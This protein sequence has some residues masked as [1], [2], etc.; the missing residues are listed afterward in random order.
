V[1]RRDT[2]QDLR[3]YRAQ[4]AL[5]WGR[6]FTNLDEIGRYIESLMASNWWAKE[7][8][9]IQD[10]EIQ[11]T[12]PRSWRA[13]SQRVPS[14]RIWLPRWGFSELAILHEIAHCL[15]LSGG[16]HGPMWVSTFLKLARR[17]MGTDR[18]NAIRAE[19]VRAGVRFRN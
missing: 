17:A 6:R 9:H 18:A 2:A 7:Y 5:P 13:Y 15:T 16:H 11:Q 8:P 14:P 1:G 12:S 10:I 4:D 3:V 19:F